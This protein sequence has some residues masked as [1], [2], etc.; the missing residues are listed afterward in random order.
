MPKW[1]RRVAFV[2][3]LVTCVVSIA[4]CVAIEAAK[5]AYRSYRRVQAQGW[6]GA[7]KYIAVD[8]VLSVGSLATRGIS[9]RYVRSQGIR[10]AQKFILNGSASLP[11]YVRSG[12]GY[13]YNGTGRR[14]AFYNPAG[15][16]FLAW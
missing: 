3:G 9:A 1:A 5:F 16:R 6:R 14:N 11:H 7:G 4:A 13:Y 15:R 8:A 12:A 10:G 2:G